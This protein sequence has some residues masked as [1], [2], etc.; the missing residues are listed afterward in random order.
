MSPA[1]FVIAPFLA[2]GA[3][4]V[5]NVLFNSGAATV[6]GVQSDGVLDAASFL[7]GAVAPGKLIT[8]TG[9]GIGPASTQDP[10]GSSSV[11][12]LD[13]AS[14][15]FDGALPP[16]LYGFVLGSLSSGP[17]TPIVLTW[18]TASSRV[19]LAVR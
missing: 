1:A 17:S 19:T 16:M 6:G 4:I 14:V 3:V 18:G 9:C 13:G 7:P 12:P 8:L 15:P 2:P 10:A 5:G 11:T